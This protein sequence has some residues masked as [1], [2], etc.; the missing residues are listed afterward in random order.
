MVVEAAEEFSRH[1]HRDDGE[2]VASSL[3]DGLILLRDLL[4]CRLHDDVER[5]VGMDSMLTP[6]SES[7]T[8]RVAKAEIT[9]YQIAES[10]VAAGNLGRIGRDDD[11]YW[12]WLARLGFGESQVSAKVVERI[13]S[14]LSKTPHERQL[15]FSNVMARAVPESR[16][17]PLI[18]FDLLPLAIQIV[19]AVALGDQ[20]SALELRQRQLARQPAIGDCRLCHGQVRGNG[21]LCTGCGNPLWKHEWLVAE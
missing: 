21:E 18:L 20:T 13:T 7:K 15:A 4:Y 1:M 17:A 8:R 10:N 6:V 14:Y 16:R 3:S 19:T 9:A 2:R 11:W 12:R 5:I